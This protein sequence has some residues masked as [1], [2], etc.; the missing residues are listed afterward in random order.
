MD[1]KSLNCSEYNFYLESKIWQ[2]DVG[3]SVQDKVHVNGDQIGFLK[4]FS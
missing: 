4:I 3:L 2:Y 1:G